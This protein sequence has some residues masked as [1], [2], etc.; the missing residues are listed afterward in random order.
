M[1]D[2]G[3]T[4]AKF[5]VAITGGIASGKSA[6]TGFFAGLGITVV[7]AD[8]AAR[9]VVE[10]G[11]PALEEIASCFGS[12]LIIEGQLNRQALREFIFD[13]A[14]AKKKLELIT[15]PRIRQLLI[16]ECQAAKSAYAI[17]AIPLLAE[18]NKTHYAWINRILVVDADREIQKSRLLARDNITESL[19]DKMLD[20]QASRAQRLAI[21]DDV[22]SNMHDRQSLQ[23]SVQRLDEN[24]RKLALTISMA[25][26][27]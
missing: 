10:A 4:M 15:H 17:V 11:Q 13:N 16:Q 14:D 25:K 26:T 27:G 8:M 5:I 24:Y 9:A 23:E 3:L 19:A 12:H 1:D 22:I 6:V 7:D 21:A 20:A 18:S 2:V